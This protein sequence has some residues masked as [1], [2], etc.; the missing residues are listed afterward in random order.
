MCVI[1]KKDFSSADSPCYHIPAGK[2][3]RIQIETPPETETSFS[4]LKT[5][6]KIKK[7]VGM[8]L[9]GLAVSLIVG[10]TIALTAHGIGVLSLSAAAVA[11]LPQMYAPAVMI[12]WIGS[13][14]L[15]NTSLKKPSFGIKSAPFGV[16][17]A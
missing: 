14:C 2:P 7:I 11:A 17:F 1:G 4:E 16:D 10:A 12:L 3:L 8:I 5:S 9:V 15:S 13:I 6:Q